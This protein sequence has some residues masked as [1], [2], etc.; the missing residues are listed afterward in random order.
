MIESNN[1]KCVTI[2]V[3]GETGVG[4]S[5]IGNAFL[6][7]KDMFEIN[8][9][10]DSS[11]FETSS[12]SNYVNGIMRQFIDTQGLSST[13]SLDS[14]HIQQ[15]VNFLKESQLKINA[16]FIALNIQCPRFNKEIQMMFQLINDFYNNPKLW[17]QTGI[18]FTRCYQGYFDRE[19]AETRYRPKI[20]NFIKKLP[21]CQNIEPELPCFFV[22]SPNW[23]HDE[24]TR[25]EYDRVLEYSLKFQPFLSNQFKYAM[26]EYKQKEEELLENVLV[27]SEY[28]VTPNSSI[29]EKI[30]FYENQ[31]RYKIID[32]NDEILYTEPVTINSWTEKKKSRIEVETK[33]EKNRFIKLKNKYDSLCNQNFGDN[34][35]QNQTHDYFVE[36]TIYT[37][38]KRN[39]YID[40]DGNATF[41]DWNA[42]NEW[43]E[44]K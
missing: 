32:R 25:R 36:K 31:I 29:K 39:I 3:I 19:N 43:E 44:I 34:R 24:S 15:M 16:I 14:E 40:P 30:L 11:T 1:K 26:A 33:I 18:I 35:H 5:S 9:D 8:S 2:L 21:G 17:N 37:Q 27:R 28:V 22:D 4:K 20:I 41:G 42:N 10:P 38:Y 12:K 23:E 13:D 6:N 7:K